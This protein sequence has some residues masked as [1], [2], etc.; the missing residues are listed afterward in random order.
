[1]A[2][3]LAATAI[4]SGFCNSTDDVKQQM[5]QSCE[6]SMNTAGLARKTR[7]SRSTLSPAS[8]LVH[9]CLPCSHQRRVTSAL[10]MPAHAQSLNAKNARSAV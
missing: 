2:L 5:K 4:A 8:Q 6:G 3:S 7:M 1:M 9:S 10:R